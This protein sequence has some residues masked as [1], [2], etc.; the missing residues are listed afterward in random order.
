MEII[1]KNDFYKVLKMADELGFYE[2][3]YDYIYNRYLRANLDIKD[4]LLK[5]LERDDEFHCM[6]YGVACDIGVIFG[7]DK[8][9]NFAIINLN[10][11]ISQTFNELIKP[12]I[13]I[14]FDRGNTDSEF[15]KVLK[16]SNYL[17]IDIDKL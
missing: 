11:G 17:I 10:A 6:E 9:L 2:D 16:K 14:Y 15:I 7:F 5:K 4:Q 13:N 8:N 1:S 12:D 3:K